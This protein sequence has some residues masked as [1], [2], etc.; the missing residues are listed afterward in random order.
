MFNKNKIYDCFIFFNELELLEIRLN[1]LSDVVDCFVLVESTRTFSGKDKELYYLRNKVLF[2][3]FNHKIIH[4][5]VDDMPETNNRWELEFFQRNAILRGLN[6]CKSED[7]ILIS[8]VDE[9]PNKHR[10]IENISRISNLPKV[11]NQKLYYYYLNCIA[12][13][14][15]DGTVMIKYKYL[16]LH[17]IFKINS[18]FHRIME[19]FK[20][21]WTPQRLRHKRHTFE[22]INDGGWHFSY[23]GGIEKIKTKIMSFA[24]AEFSSDYYRNNERLLQAIENGS[25]LFGRD[26]KYH[27]VHIDKTYPEYLLKNIDRYKHLIKDFG[28]IKTFA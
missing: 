10:L 26:Y 12:N 2:E 28:D 13:I 18:V 11:F 1:E 8:D 24:H 9:I 27:Y 22:K 4:V 20:F 5:V 6:N 7:I 16:K 21:F 14:K 25:D 15:W 23:L 3:E 17:Q 19:K